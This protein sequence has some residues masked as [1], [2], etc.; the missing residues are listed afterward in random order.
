[1]PLEYTAISDLNSSKKEWKIRV[2][3][4]RMWEYFS[5]NKPEVVLGLEAILVDEKVRTQSELPLSSSSCS[6]MQVENISSEAKN[7]GLPPCSPLT[8]ITKRQGSL[9]IDDEAIQESSTSSKRTYKK[10]R[11]ESDSKVEN[12]KKEST[13]AKH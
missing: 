9:I 7:N 1:M 13:K 10:A 6:G 4:S 12:M 3:V 8:P 11:G 5:K 2:L